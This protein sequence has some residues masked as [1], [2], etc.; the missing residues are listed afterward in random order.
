MTAFLFRRELDRL[1]NNWLN[2]PEWTRTEI[3]EFPGTVGGP[4]DRY[5]E[6]DDFREDPPPKY[7]RLSVGREVRLRYAYLITCVGVVKDASGQ[8]VELH[9]TYDPETKSGEA[10]D[11]RKVKATLHWVAAESAIPI[12]VRLY[13]NLFVKPDPDDVVEGQ[14]YLSNLNPRSLEVRMALAEESLRNAQVGQRFQFERQ[15]YFCVDKDSTPD[16]L[17]FNRTATLRDEWAK[18]NKGRKKT[19]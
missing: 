4:W 5:I 18:I 1:R 15:G 12:E 13:D 10:K 19:G 9:C 14:D 11:G 17:V 8:V 7:Y 3:L 6:R 16:R 2:P